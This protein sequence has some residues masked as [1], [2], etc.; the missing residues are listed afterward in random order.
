LANELVAMKNALTA[1]CR[2]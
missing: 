1:H 2:Y